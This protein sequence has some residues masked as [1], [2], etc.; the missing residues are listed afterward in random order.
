[1]KGSM[2]EVATVTPESLE[3]EQPENAAAHEPKSLIQI[4]G[5]N[6]PQSPVPRKVDYSSYSNT[7]PNSPLNEPPPPSPFPTSPYFQLGIVPSKIKNPPTDF[8]GNRRAWFFSR[9]SFTNVLTDRIS[10]MSVFNSTRASSVRESRDWAAKPHD[11]QYIS[12]M[13][14]RQ[15]ADMMNQAPSTRAFTKVKVYAPEDRPT[16]LDPE[17]GYLEY[18]AEQSRKREIE[19]LEALNRKKKLCKWMGPGASCI[20]VIVFIALLFFTSY[21]Y[22]SNFENNEVEEA[23][24]DGTRLLVDQVLLMLWENNEH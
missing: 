21:R 4:D 13:D 10:R 12:N 23:K 15:M 11:S 6:F 5:Q 9:T 7:P 17:G 2:I 3:Q 8:V 19:K 14:E 18:Y 22:R 16:E 24:P 20:S 1:M